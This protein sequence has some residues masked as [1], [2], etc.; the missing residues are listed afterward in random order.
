M[1]KLRAKINNE[2]NTYIRKVKNCV[3]LN[4]GRREKKYQIK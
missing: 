2:K 3:V 4:M 1:E